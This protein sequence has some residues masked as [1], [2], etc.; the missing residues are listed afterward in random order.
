MLIGIMSDS[1]GNMAAIGKAVDFFNE[2]AI[3][4]LYHAGDIDS[5]DTFAEFRRLSCPMT[6]VFGNCDSER[7][8]FREKF[9][10]KGVF[11]G[12]KHSFNIN[13]KK[14][15]MMHEP[16]DLERLAETGCYDCIIYGHTHRIDARLVRGTLIINPGEISGLRTGKISVV[17]L[18]TSTMQHELVF[19]A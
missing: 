17:L 18:E 13:E 3:E 8:S 5:P 1:H 6:L 9:R 15:L 4:H 12:Q 7:R 16:R 11:H 2:R 10:G 19:L 14:I